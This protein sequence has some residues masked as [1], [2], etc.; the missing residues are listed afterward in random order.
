MKQITDLGYE[1]SKQIEQSKF[2]NE[3]KFCEETGRNRQT[4]NQTIR[5][6]KTGEGANL[7]NV[8]EILEILGLRLIIEK[9]GEK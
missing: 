8:C 2:K 6:L 3:T 7:K 1:L 5:R 9:K 4:F